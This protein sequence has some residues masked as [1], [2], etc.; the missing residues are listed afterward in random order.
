MKKEEKKE[1]KKEGEEKK[2]GGNEMERR[3][4]NIEEE[5]EKRGDTLV[6]C[7][8]IIKYNQHVFLSDPAAQWWRSSPATH[9]LSGRNCLRFTGDLTLSLTT[10][11]YDQP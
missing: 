2:E 10:V 6:Q 4:R 8:N 3:G 1:S 5:G 7:P 9:H 11:V